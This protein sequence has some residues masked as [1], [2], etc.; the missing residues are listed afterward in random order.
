MTLLQSENGYII[1]DTKRFILC[2]MFFKNT[3]TQI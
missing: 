1:I 2:E 3:Q